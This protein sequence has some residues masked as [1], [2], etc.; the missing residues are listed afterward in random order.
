MLKN[1]EPTRKIREFT[2]HTFAYIRTY[3]LVTHL[4]AYKTA[5]TCRVAKSNKTLLRSMVLYR[6]YS[7]FT[8]SLVAQNLSNF[9]HFRGYQPTNQ[10]I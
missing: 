2:T 3:V 5:E 9:L 8:I 1:C 7:K 4:M 6:S 10:S